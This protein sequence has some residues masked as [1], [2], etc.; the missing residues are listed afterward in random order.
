[1]S[2][3]PNI[4][5]S[6][7]PF[8][9]AQPVL[10]AARQTHAPA[11]YQ[12]HADPGQ[13]MVTQG[14]VPVMP[15]FFVSE[16]APERR[17]AIQ[18]NGEVLG[19]LEFQRSHEKW[20]IETYSLKNQ[21]APEPALRSVPTCAKFVAVRVNPWDSART[22]AIVRNPDDSGS[23]RT[24]VQYDADGM[25][26]QPAVTETATGFE[27]A[28]KPEELAAAVAAARAGI[29]EE[30]PNLEPEPKLPA[31]VTARCGA[32]VEKSKH[33]PHVRFHCVECQRL[34]AAEKLGEAG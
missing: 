18:E 29:T 33:G 3:D 8:D 13:T 15:G 26:P 20:Y 9:V 2:A 5:A 19:E 16:V 14:G 27:L 22:E 34:R 21:P 31:M 25:N 30:D 24:L 12:K 17:W 10:F 32:Q 7:D 28:G 4:F 11:W 1:V 23:R 6:E